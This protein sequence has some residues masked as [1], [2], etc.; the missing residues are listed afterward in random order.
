MCI[1]ITQCVHTKEQ[2]SLYSALLFFDEKVESFRERVYVTL[3]NREHGW[4]AIMLPTSKL[5]TPKISSVEERV[6]MVIARA[7]RHSRREGGD[8]H[9][10]IPKLVMPR[11]AHETPVNKGKQVGHIP[12][13]IEIHC[14]QRRLAPATRSLNKT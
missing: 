8:G 10:T 3:M 6:G 2:T 12:H 4:A 7:I 11:Q 14:D 13:R 5:H 1:P 9:M